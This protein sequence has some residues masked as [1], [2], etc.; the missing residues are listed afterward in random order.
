M[1]GS[2]VSA[3]VPSPAKPFLAV[4]E[5]SVDSLMSNTELDIPVTLLS[6]QALKRPL[7]LF[8]LT[9]SCCKSCLIVDSKVT[10]K[11]KHPVLLSG[12]CCLWKVQVSCRPLSVPTHLCLRHM[13]ERSMCRRTQVSGCN[14]V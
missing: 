3:K 5:S 13:Y 9:M 12:L 6:A 10:R 11:E 8:F 1:G 4:G 7:H 2:L 14:H